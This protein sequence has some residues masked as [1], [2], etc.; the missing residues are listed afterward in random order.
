M[1][2]KPPKFHDWLAFAAAL[3][4]GFLTLGSVGF[5]AWDLDTLV[6]RPKRQK[7]RMQGGEPIVVPRYQV[8]CIRN[9]RD[10]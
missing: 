1:K 8:R 9:G 4:V 6:T 2:E 10:I 3:L 7:C 5:V